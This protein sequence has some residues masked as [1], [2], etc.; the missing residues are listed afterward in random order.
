MFCGLCVGV[1]ERREE[2]THLIFADE[3]LLFC[4]LEKEAFLNLRCVLMGFQVVSGLNINL[5]KSELVTLG[6]EEG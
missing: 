2:V 3:V 5:P 6:K 4:V 1:G